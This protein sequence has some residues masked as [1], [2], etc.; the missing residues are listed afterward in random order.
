M[1]MPPALAQ[2]LRAANNRLRAL[3]DTPFDTNAPSALP[4]WT[5]AHVLTHLAN[6]AAAFTRQAEFA[7]AGNQIEVYD[8]GRPARD[9]AIEQGATQPPKTLRATLHTALNTL[10]AT[11]DKATPAD[12]TRP[13]TYRDGTLLDTALAWWREAEIHTTDL[14]LAYTPTEW[15]PEFTAY[16]T[17]Y[18]HPRLPHPVTLEGTPT[19]VAAWLAGRVPPTPV[20]AADGTPLPTLNSWP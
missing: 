5:R 10:D 12:W 3:L 2:A 16:L 4:G 11:W 18:L 15:T 19:A 9:A 7:Y 6:L 17:T 8:G 14:A 1:T 20:T 13:V